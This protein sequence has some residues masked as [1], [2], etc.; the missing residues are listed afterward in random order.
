MITIVFHTEN[1]ASETVTLRTS[2]D[3]WL[4]DLPGT[5]SGGAWRYQLTGAQYDKG[6]TF[7]FYLPLFKGWSEFDLEIQHGSTGVFNYDET[8]VRFPFVISL[9]RQR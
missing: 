1:Y 9:I 2:I 4:V 7:K 6:F 3:R 5:Y 8:Q